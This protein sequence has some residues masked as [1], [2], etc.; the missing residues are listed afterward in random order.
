MDFST[1]SGRSYL[2]LDCLYL[3]AALRGQG[4][5]RRL[6]GAVIDEARRRGCR[7]VQWQTPGWNAGAISFYERIGARGA[8]KV[9]FTI[10]TTPAEGTA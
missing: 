1:W 6:M 7:E 4:W 5:G 3:D 10:P 8:A 2:H 9:R